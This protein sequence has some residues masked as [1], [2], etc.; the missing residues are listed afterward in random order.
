MAKMTVLSFIL[1]LVLVLSIENMGVVG[2]GCC[3]DY[4]RGPCEHGKDDAAPDGS[5]FKFC[6]TQQFCRDA[7]CKNNNVCHCAC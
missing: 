2:D 6:T 7:L 4:H 5:C 1:I 3:T